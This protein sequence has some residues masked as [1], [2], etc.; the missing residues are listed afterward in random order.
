MI[1]KKEYLKAK[2]IVQ[3]YEKSTC[4]HDWVYKTFG[5]LPIPP[6]KYCSKCNKM[7]KI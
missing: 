7:K 3:E 2:K 4:Q 1:K 6:F 5:W